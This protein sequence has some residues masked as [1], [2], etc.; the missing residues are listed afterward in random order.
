[1]KK[2]LSLS[3]IAL[4][5]TNFSHIRSIHEI[6]TLS[7]FQSFI[8]KD[9]KPVVIKFHATWCPACKAMK[10]IFDQASEKYKD[11]AHFATINV[12]KKELK[13]AL[14][15]F[16]IQGIPTI[17]YKKTGF[18]AE[19]AFNNR[20]KHFLSTP[21]KKDKKIQPKQNKKPVLNKKQKPENKTAKKTNKNLKNK[22]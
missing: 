21:E 11:A 10:P 22:Q 17:I 5:L 20:L 12:E 4:A 2:S 8:H 7:D 1:M 13:P 6:N 16:G 19:E 15:A 9:D 14:E 18:E 3:L